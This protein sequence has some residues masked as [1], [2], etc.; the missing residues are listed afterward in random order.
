MGTESQLTHRLYEA[1]IKEQV[2][3]H[4]RVYRQQ[5]EHE[6]IRTRHRGGEGK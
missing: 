1:V 2:A 6:K 4:G 5:R 3:D